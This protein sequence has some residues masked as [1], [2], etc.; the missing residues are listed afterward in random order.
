MISKWAYAE[1]AAP[2]APGLF[3][4][5]WIFWVRLPSLIQ[6]SV[7][8]VWGAIEELIRKENPTIG[9]ITSFGCYMETRLTE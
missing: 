4:N 3:G 7:E 2:N 8:K 5:R 9:D 6:S 1:V